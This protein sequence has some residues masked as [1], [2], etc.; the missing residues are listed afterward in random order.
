M[1]AATVVMVAGIGLVAIL[2]QT[3]GY[4]MGGVMVLPL[5][6]IYTFREPLSL[7]IF[8]AGTVVAWGALW[9][10]REYTLNHGRRLFLVAVGTGALATIVAGY[11]VSLAMPQ[12]L[13]FESAE[14]IASIFP[15]VT[16][17]NLMRVD[18]EDRRADLLAMVATYVGLCGVGLGALWVLADVGSP[19]PPVLALPTSDVVTWAGIE[20]RGA[21]FP[22]ITPQWL[23]VGLLVADVV[24]YELM[25]K[26]Y[27][28]RLAGIILIP[29]LAVFSVRYGNTVLVY[30]IGATVVFFLVSYV[31]WATLL[32]GRVLLGISLVLGSLYTV[33]VGIWQ[34]TSAP[35]ITLF[36][37]GLFVGIGAYNLHRVAP[38]SRGAHIRISAA[39]F[40]VFY[41]II[42]RFVDVPPSGLVQS[43]DPATALLGLLVVAS[44]ARELYRLEQS[45]PDADAFARESVFASV[46]IDGV[47]VE[48]S[49]LVASEEDR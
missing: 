18:A 1:I 17:Y 15:G 20:A 19:S 24:V 25:R 34:P 44:G 37:I 5:L 2:S 49:P 47:D 32:Y 4:R 28:H 30:G 10:T 26:R 41:A 27:D 14:A 31:H 46:N 16:A 29:L 48:E 45:I 23:T 33:T 42:L 12:Q 40:V 3:R 35:G 13:P 43:I 39:L 7:V 21:A 6:V 9:A 36:F 8:A 11:L 38:K 22:R